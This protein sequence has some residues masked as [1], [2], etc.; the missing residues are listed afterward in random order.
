MDAEYR[1]DLQNSYLVLKMK[2]ETENRYPL[3][4]ITENKI[5]GLLPCSFR[6][7]NGD[8]LFY[9]DITSKISLAERCQCRKMTG[10]NFLVLICSLIR[11]LSAMEE[12]LL[13]GNSLCLN[14]E[15]IFLDAQM[16]AVNF[17]C[18]PC[19]VWNLE[20]SFRELMEG[21]L[22][23]IDHQSQKGVMVGY[24]FY[25]YAVRESFSLD[26]LREQ[27]EI[28]QKEDRKDGLQCIEEDADDD[29]ENSLRI[30]LTEKESQEE[31]ESRWL[32]QKKHEAA[33]NAFFQD[34]EE[35]QEDHSHPFLVTTGT[36]GVFLFGLTGW[37]LWRNYRVY[38]WIWGAIGI[39]FLIMTF[40]YTWRERK[41]GNPG[42]QQD[43]REN[44]KKELFMGFE[45]EECEKKEK[46][47]EYGQDDCLT[48]V[49]DQSREKG[50]FILEE[51]YPN[52]G[53]CI[54]LEKREIC[55]IG[56]L[57]EMADIVLPSGAV[58]RLHARIRM[59]EDKCY[60]RDLNSKNGTWVN[61]QEVQG[62][63]EIEIKEGDEIRFADLTYILRRT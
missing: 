51:K 19:E 58:S 46:V 4:M 28:Y 3:R 26:G 53:Q 13:D 16:Q 29:R 11:V 63:K 54:R 14:M 50:V 34:E 17:C 49:L 45:P 35:K 38:L 37:Y 36:V 40:F 9:Y 8:V 30:D 31:K 47:V 56:K 2:E 20:N 23:C 41:G 33:L 15:Y 6:R 44:Q 21:L 62:E 12:Y 22:P 60:L 52:K 24:G 55:F 59:D 10:E 1:R 57:K 32:E 7:M 42:G 27:L 5:S 48:Q 18:V 39:L 25:Q 43:E 61:G